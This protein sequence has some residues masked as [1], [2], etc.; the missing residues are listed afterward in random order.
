MLN[1]VAAPHEL[2][3]VFELE[4]IFKDL[5]FV[6]LKKITREGWSALELSR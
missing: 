6:A 2:D 1:L 5:G 3:Q 4:R